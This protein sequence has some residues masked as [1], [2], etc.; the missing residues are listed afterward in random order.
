[1]SAYVTLWLMI[2]LYIFATLEFSMTTLITKIAEATLR[3]QSCYTSQSCACTSSATAPC[4]A[5]YTV[6]MNVTCGAHLIRTDMH[7]TSV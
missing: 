3:R 4:V 1:M 7:N 6:A 5:G 2:K